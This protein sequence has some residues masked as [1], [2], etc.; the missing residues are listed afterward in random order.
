MGGSRPNLKGTRYLA[1]NP[2]VACFVV[3]AKDIMMDGLRATR[4]AVFVYVGIDVYSAIVADHSSG[5][6]F[7]AL[8]IKIGSDIAQSAAATAVGILAGAFLST[9]GAPV[10]V[11]FVI[12]VLIGLGVGAALYAVD[13]RYRLTEQAQ[14]YWSK[15]EA[16]P[17]SPLYRFHN[18]VCG[19]FSRFWNSAEEMV[20]SFVSLPNTG[21]DPR[22]SRGMIF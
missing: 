20:Q 13:N 12:V 9:A 22:P 16:T 10:V 7:A 4:L 21:H 1:T 14:D 6:S 5:T 11:T 18:G 8:G 17:G 2:K 19:A 15:I 3:G